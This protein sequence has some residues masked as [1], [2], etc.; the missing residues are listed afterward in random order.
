MTFRKLIGKLHLWLGL[1]SGLVVFV[2][3]I[4][5]CIYV[6][7]SEIRSLYEYP[8]TEIKPENKPVLAVSTVQKIGKTVLEKELKTQI[9]PDYENVTLYKNPTKALYYYV[10]DEKEKLSHYVFINPYSGEVLKIKDMNQDFFSFVLD[11]HMNLL[12]PYEIGHQIV[13]VAVLIFVVSLI[14]GLILW[15]PKSKK[16][17]KQRFSIRWNARWKRKNYDLHNVFGFYALPFALIIALTGLVFSYDWVGKGLDWLANGGK[18]SPEIQETKSKFSIQKSD[19]KIDKLFQEYFLES[20]DNH[21]FTIEFPKN[22]TAAIAFVFFPNASTYYNSKTLTFDQYSG[23]L[24]QTESFETKTN[25]EKLRSMNYDIHIGKI[26]GLPGQI[27]AF[28]A[29]L[30]AA[31]LPITGFLIWR[32]RNNKLSTPSNSLAKI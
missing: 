30:V 9:K 26:L 11:L 19:L 31:S 23:D 28:F 32:G 5:G 20:P 8:F 6:F 2:V 22:D 13:G 21:L 1:V 12:L 7:E 17:I 3:A 18:Y 16:G 10:Y 29:S 27:L 24:L 25:G 15:F 4:T 14:T